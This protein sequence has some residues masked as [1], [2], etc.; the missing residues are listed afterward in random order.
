MA[1]ETLADA[2]TLSR[3]QVRRAFALTHNGFLVLN[4][5]IAS[6]RGPCFV[7]YLPAWRKA[8]DAWAAFYRDGWSPRKYDAMTRHRLELLRWRNT[9]VNVCSLVEA[10]V[11]LYASL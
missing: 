7:A 9:F 6:Q 11:P 4:N 8:R 5:E 10:D 3:D 2:S 1:L